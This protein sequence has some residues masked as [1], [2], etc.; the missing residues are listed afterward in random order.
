MA[1]NSSWEIMIDQ[2]SE[3]CRDSCFCSII[4]ERTMC[5]SRRGSLNWHF[6]NLGERKGLAFVSTLRFISIGHTVLWLAFLLPLQCI[7]DN[8]SVSNLTIEPRTIVPLALIVRALLQ[9][10]TSFLVMALSSPSPH[11][12]PSTHQT[13]YTY[14][15]ATKKYNQMQVK[16]LHRFAIKELSGDSLS[17]VRF[18]AGA[19]TLEDDRRFALMYDE[20]RAGFVEEHPSWLHKVSSIVSVHSLCCHR[21]Y[22]SV[23]LMCRTTFSV[24]SQHQNS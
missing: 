8:R 11:P 13:T 9:P 1:Y 17:F 22:L 24:H 16:F 23:K 14:S 12:Q 21:S 19:G 20:A 6:P 10:P 2:W 5:H 18:D 3:V 15:P 4:S 7:S